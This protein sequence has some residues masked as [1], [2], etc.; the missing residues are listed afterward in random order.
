MDYQVL[1]SSPDRLALRENNDCSVVA[2]TVATDLPYKVV[3]A[4]FKKWGRR[5]RQG[6]CFSQVKDAAYELGYKLTRI[7]CDAKTVMNVPY[8][9]TKNGHFGNFVIYATRHC[10]GMTGG[11]V[12]DWTAGRRIRVKGVYKVEKI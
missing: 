8:H 9:L 11:R 6:V 2:L 7:Q 10:A 1:R 4:A 5:N 3:H 12:V